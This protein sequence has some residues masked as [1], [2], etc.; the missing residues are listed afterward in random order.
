MIKQ[1]KN[2]FG[3]NMLLAVLFYVCIA[4]TAYVLYRLPENL[5]IPFGSHGAFTTVYITIAITLL[6][7][8]VAINMAM[9]YK[10][11]LIVYRDRVKD[12]SETDEAIDESKTTISLDGIRN[13]LRQAHSE[14]DILQQGLHAVCKQLEA[15]Q[16][17]AYT[18]LKEEDKKTVELKTGYALTISESTRV[19]YDLGEGLIGQSAA[20]GQLLYLDEIPEGYIKI[21]SGLG[22]ASP[23]YLVIAPVK[24]EDEV[25]GVLEIASF[26]NVTDDQRKFINESAQLIG[27]KLKS[28]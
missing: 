17:A 23:R 13:A 28:N 14:R 5:M 6:V 21:V 2:S 26:K 4:I 12:K 11:E 16:G 9:R 25:V 1:V 10:R 19:H 27:Q 20:S 3:L 7:G 15:G 8:I 22:S 24:N 18:I